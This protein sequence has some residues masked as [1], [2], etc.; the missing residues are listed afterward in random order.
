MGKSGAA[1]ATGVTLDNARALDLGVFK[2]GLL[3]VLDL[4]R[5]SR[6]PM[7]RNSYDQPEHGIVIFGF[8]QQR[9]VCFCVRR[10]H[11][12]ENAIRSC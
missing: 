2:G 8:Y 12:S 11:E 10:L 9:C 4:F 7:V 5:T 1:N 6:V 3:N